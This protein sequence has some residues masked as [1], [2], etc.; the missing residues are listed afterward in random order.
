VIAGLWRQ[1]LWATSDG[2]A[3]LATTRGTGQGSAR[4][5]NGPSWISYDPHNPG[6]FYESGIQYG[7]G[8]FATTNGGTTFAQLGTVTLN[9]FGPVGPVFAR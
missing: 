3:S 1:G 5:T 2:G 7:G 4:V 8:A 6:R 9:D